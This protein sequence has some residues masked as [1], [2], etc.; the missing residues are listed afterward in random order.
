M[1][2][3]A[4][5]YGLLVNEGSPVT[6]GAVPPGMARIVVAR[7]VAS[8]PGCPNWDTPAQANYNNRTMPNFG[9]SVNANLIAQVANP[10]D[11]V[12]GRAA[13]SAG[14]V[15]TGGKAINLYRNWQL[16]AVLPGQVERPLKQVE[17]TTTRGAR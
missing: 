9:C 11:L 16:T 1:A 4:G 7:S 3:V 5:K 10:E 8:V 15:I 14:D 17:S 6:A 2:R 13:A 12:R